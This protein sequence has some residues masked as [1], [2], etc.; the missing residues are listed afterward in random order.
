MRDR[1]ENK[2]REKIYKEEGKHAKER[3]KTSIFGTEPWTAN[4]ERKRPDNRS[5]TTFQISAHTLLKACT[6]AAAASN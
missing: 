4:S 2:R 5:S 6:A 1:Q 3:K